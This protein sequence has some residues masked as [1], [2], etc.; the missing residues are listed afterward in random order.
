MI[1]FMIDE[2]TPCL[3]SIKSGEIFETEVI[4]FIIALCAKT[5]CLCF[6]FEPCNERLERIGVI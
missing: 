3:K 2:L 5:F 6:C 1:T 4:S